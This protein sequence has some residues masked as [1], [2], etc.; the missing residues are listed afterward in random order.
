MK[1]LITCL[2]WISLPLLFSCGSKGSD[3]PTED[4]LVVNLSATAIQI[5]TS[6]AYVL[7]V[8]ITSKMPAQ[9]VTVKVDVKREDNGAA[10]YNIQANSS[11]SS[12][13]F[14]ISPL[15]PG[16]IYCTATVTVTSVTKATNVWTGT[17]R[18]LWK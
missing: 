1:Q 13:N 17:F 16:Q 5:S 9:G 18:V 11:L 4:N 2:I 15:P 10:V 14:T 6:N 8:N 7:T 12:S 3:T